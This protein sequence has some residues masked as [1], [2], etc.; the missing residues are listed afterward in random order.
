M[1]YFVSLALFPTYLFFLSSACLPAVPHVFQI[2]NHILQ[3]AKP[4]TVIYLIPNSFELPAYVWKTPGVEYS[5]TILI[6]LFLFL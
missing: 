4:Q 3:G 1:V 6:H 2:L 5:F